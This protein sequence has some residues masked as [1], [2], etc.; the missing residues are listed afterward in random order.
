MQVRK[1]K[2]SSKHAIQQHC[3]RLSNPTFW[4]LASLGELETIRDRCLLPSSPSLR[5]P[6]PAMGLDTLASCTITPHDAQ[7]VGIEAIL[8]AGLSSVQCWMTSLPDFP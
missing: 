3:L 7:K 5:H 6:L 2:K 1:L 8:I 4:R